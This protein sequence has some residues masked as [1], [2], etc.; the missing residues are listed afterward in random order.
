LNRTTRRIKHYAWI[1]GIYFLILVVLVPLGLGMHIQK[2]TSVKQIFVGFN[3]LG[4]S[5]PRGTIIHE[6]DSDFNVFSN[7]QYPRAVIRI[8]QTDNDIT[9]WRRG[10]RLPLATIKSS[11]LITVT[12]ADGV[13]EEVFDQHWHWPPFHQITPREPITP[14]ME[15]ALEEHPNDYAEIFRDMF[16]P[17]TECRVDPIPEPRQSTLSSLTHQALNDGGYEWISDAVYQRP[18]PVIRYHYTELLILLSV[19]IGI[20]F[21]SILLEEISE[22]R[23]Q[24]KIC[25]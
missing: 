19:F 8:E 15:K 7:P 4:T 23:K 6:V 25:D 22:R 12:I 20:L 16:A 21:I 10:K 9:V 13:D 24:R 1:L 2:Q 5:S 18:Q 3:Q 14:M 17:Q 11:S